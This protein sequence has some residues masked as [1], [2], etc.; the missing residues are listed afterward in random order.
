[1][2]ANTIL[3]DANVL[4]R[5]L[6][7][8]ALLGHIERHKPLRGYAA[9]DCNLLVGLLSS[10]TTVS[11]TP[12][13][14]TEA[15]NLARQIDGPARTG[16]TRALRRF[17]PGA[18]EIHVPSTRATGADMYLRLGVTDA[19]LLDVEFADHLL[20]TAGLDLWLEAARR[21]RKA[22]NFVHHIA[23]DR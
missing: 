13:T 18:Q 7:G 1:M 15:A 2:A 17:L 22:E 19:G 3:L 21:G 5:F 16:I 8:A 6:A 9:G 20:P 12:N 10:A 11:V 4:V 14:V 23:A